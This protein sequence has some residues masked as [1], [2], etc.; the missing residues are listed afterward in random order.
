MV[1]IVRSARPAAVLSVLALAG[2]GAP[3]RA[4]PPAPAV[5]ATVVMTEWSVVIAPRTIPAGKAT[6][7][8]RNV[9][10][11]THAV[12][13]E[14]D[15]ASTEIEG[16]E[17]APGQSETLVVHLTPGQWVVDCSMVSPSARGSH[18]L[19]GMSTTL[20]VK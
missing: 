12:E 16:D 8:V 2:F 9:G 3:G 4:A 7:L 18:A 6:I 10:R 19:R 13:I 15:A 20:V 11:Q 14:N 1:G 17:L 5:T